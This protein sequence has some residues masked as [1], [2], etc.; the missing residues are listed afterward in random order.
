MG[1]ASGKHRPRRRRKPCTVPIPDPLGLEGLDIGCDELKVSELSSWFE[2]IAG[3][4]D[5]RWSRVENRYL[6][7]GDARF[8][9]TL[10][11]GGAHFTGAD[12]NQT[13]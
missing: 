3:E 7:T 6:V 4:L 11:H 9:P 1:R 12:Q 13:P 5:E 2:E 10:Q 8:Q